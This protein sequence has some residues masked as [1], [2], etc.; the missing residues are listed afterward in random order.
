MDTINKS[1]PKEA[2]HYKPPDE[3]VKLQYQH[4]LKLDTPLDQ[5]NVKV[6]FDICVSF[7]ILLIVTPFLI[8]LKILYVVEGLI[9]PNNAG[10]MFFSYNA[11]SAGN[12]FKKYKLRL[13]KMKYIIFIPPRCASGRT[14]PPWPPRLRLLSGHI[15]AACSRGKIEEKNENSTT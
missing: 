6:I 8:L 10:P 13:I 14:C 5:R 1:E 12:I 7:I 15:S 4:I 2:F 3:Q 11:V 9:I